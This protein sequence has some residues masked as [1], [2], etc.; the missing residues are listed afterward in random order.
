[1]PNA[2]EERSE[3]TGAFAFQAPLCSGEE[4]G[5]SSSKSVTQRE[6]AASIPSLPEISVCLLHIPC[7]PLWLPRGPQHSWGARYGL[8]GAAL[9]PHLGIHFPGF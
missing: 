7:S 1:M 4:I 2:D 6:P 8:Q 5:L 3:G 9:C